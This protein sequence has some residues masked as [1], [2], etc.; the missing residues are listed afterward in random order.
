MPGPPL[1]SVQ[2]FLR[3]SVWASHGGVGPWAPAPGRWVA[4]QEAGPFAGRHQCGQLCCVRASGLA[5]CSIR[6]W[7]QTAPLFSCWDC[8]EAGWLGWGDVGWRERHEV[9]GTCWLCV[10]AP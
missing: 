8:W 6:A 3:V 1:V 2:A 9:P 10:H 5:L 4:G 7:S